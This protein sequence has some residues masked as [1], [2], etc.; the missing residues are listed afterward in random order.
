MSAI[1]HV[2]VRFPHCPN[3]I[4][5]RFFRNRAFAQDFRSRVQRFGLKVRMR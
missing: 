3:V 5:L 1:I 4:W 2:V